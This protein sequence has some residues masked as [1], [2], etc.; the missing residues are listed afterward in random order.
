[1]C[2]CVY[3]CLFLCVC[4]RACV[5]LCVCVSVSASVPVSLCFFGHSVRTL[6]GNLGGGGVWEAPRVAEPPPHVSEAPGFGPA[7]VGGLWG[8]RVRNFSVFFPVFVGLAVW[9]PSGR[10]EPPSEG[11]SA[12]RAPSL[13]APPGKIKNSRQWSENSSKKSVSFCGSRPHFQTGRIFRAHFRQPPGTK[14]TK[15]PDPPKPPFCPTK[16]CPARR[17]RKKL[18]KMV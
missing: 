2:A 1:M 10:A 11:V 13:R 12:L 6:G 8:G 9:W 7:C 18:Q 15:R 4:V 3:V 14:P 16:G 17:Q 5:R